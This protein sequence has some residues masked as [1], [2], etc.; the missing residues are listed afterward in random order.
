MPFRRRD[1]LLARARD[2]VPDGEHLL[3]VGAYDAGL[4]AATDTGLWEIAG[5]A[6]AL[7]HWDEIDSAS[8][9]PPVLRTV[10][11]AEQG[12]REWRLT[13]ARMLPDAVRDRVT[14]SVVLSEYHRLS[15]GR[16]VRIVARRRFGEDT[17]RWMLVYD[18][19]DDAN[20]PQ[21][22][23]EAERAL[24]EVRATSGI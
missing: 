9:H 1:P 22:R 18:R 10:G 3:A 16:G 23:G 20:D 21:R 12:S 11:L 2:A 17:L 13:E 15:T 14:A 8:W 24:A 19:P 7:L 4:L 5:R 6:S